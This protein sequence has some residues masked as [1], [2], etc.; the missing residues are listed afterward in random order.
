MN[1]TAILDEMRLHYICK[2]VDRFTSKFY[3]SRCL[4][5]SN[6]TIRLTDGSGKKRRGMINHYSKAI[7][8]ASSE[9]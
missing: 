6:I 2:K 8:E 5:L 4:Y 7:S 1:E 9:L 3:F